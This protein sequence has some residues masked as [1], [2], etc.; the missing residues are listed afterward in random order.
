MKQFKRRLRACP[1]L[2]VRRGVSV[3][4]LVMSVFLAAA[5]G[6]DVGTRTSSVDVS[7]ITILPGRSLYSA[8]GHTM[9]R[10]VDH[11]SGRDILYN[12]GMSAHPFDLGFVLGMLTGRMEFMVG[13]LRTTEA[14]SYYRDVENRGIIEQSLDVDEARKAAILA[15]LRYDVYKG[16]GVYNYR[17]FTDNCATRP[18]EILRSSMGDTAQGVNPAAAGTLRTSVSQALDAR[19]W[20]GLAIDTLLGPLAD[21]PLGDDT[22]IFLPKDLMRWAASA[23]YMGAE[24]RSKLVGRTEVLYSAPRPERSWSPALRLLPF[25]ALLVLAIGIT[26][27]PARAAAAGRTFDA[28][29]FGVAVVPG[30]AIL[31]FWLIAGYSEVGLNLN[32]LWA[33][34]LP[35]IAHLAGRKASH[36]RMSGILFQIAALLAGLVALCGGLG[37]QSIPMEARLVATALCLRCAGR[38][39]FL[40]RRLGPPRED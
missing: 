5:E 9:I 24:G 11:K 35:L 18:A 10:V 19:P 12:Y 33:N 25:V 7:L 15:V 6:K 29:I 17:F 2:L 4:L 21:R 1:S 27:L 3:V 37:V 20:L 13:A 31:I 14:L 22:P 28:L 40:Q 30:L 38:G 16:N 32:L 23:S 36:G 34:P 39:G 8:F 26:A